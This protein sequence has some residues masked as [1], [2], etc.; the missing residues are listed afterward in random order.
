MLRTR[1]LT[2]LTI[3]AVVA[4]VALAGTA[5]AVSPAVGTASTTPARQ[6][7]T[8]ALTPLDVARIRTAGEIAI[9]PDGSQIAFTL[10][11]PREPGSE[12]NGPA[13]SELHL[14]SFDGSDHRPFV[15]GEVNVTHV[16]WSPDG[17]YVTYAARREGDDATAIYVIPA[18]GGESRRLVHYP[19]SVSNF[20]WRP[21]G[22]AVGFIAREPVDKE[23]Q[24]LRAQG[25]NQ[26]VYE[27][28]N[29]A[30]RIV[31]VELPDGPS[32]E[33]EEPRVI[34]GIA[35]HP[36]GIAWSPE[37]DR[38]VVDPAPTPLVDD[39]YMFRRLHII[40]AA[41]GSTQGKIDNPGKLGQFGWSPDGTSV[42]VISGVDINDPMQGRLMV[43]STEGEQ[44]RDILPGLAGHIAHF[45][46]T[47][48]GNI[49]YLANIGVGAQLGRVAP[50][51]SHAEVLFRSSELVIDAFSLDASGRQIA[52]VAESPT[53]PREVFALS[54]DAPNEPQR[55]TD[56]NPWLAEIGFA[57]QEILRWNAQD[58]REIEGLLIHPIE[59]AEGERVPTIVVAHGGPESH[60]KNG[61]LTGY[62][63]PGQMAA[64]RGYAVFYPNYRGSTGRG[65]E[66]TKAH[67]GD[68]GGAE[69][70]DV[71]AGVDYLIERGIADPDRVGITGASYGGYFTAWGSTRHSERFAAGVMFVGISD[72]LSKT[73]TS[74][75]PN[76]LELV[77]WLTTPYENLD[78][79]LERSPVLYI[80][81][82]QTPLLI[83]HG[84]DDP[85]V[86]PGQSRELH[87][88]LKLKGDVP[89]RL[90][91]YPGEG[92]G[93]A[94]AAARYDYSLRMLR[95]FD[96]FLKEGGTEP[97]PWRLDYGLE[98]K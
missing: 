68:G 5:P 58:G 63:S 92:H 1:H 28:D 78:L 94:R 2:L 52:L 59:R 29:T 76:E 69:F 49:V 60:Y 34:D 8:R 85:R 73:G 25:F 27:E 36:Y 21:D 88:A 51:G 15:T 30:R 44:L 95:W 54:L 74:D 56:S 40:G 82:A 87:R 10:S 17:E 48:D 3:A 9:S 47:P 80:D 37:G 23:L 79:F 39:Q 91:L 67:Q 77:H 89:V 6:A 42:V 14:V 97:P 72:Q 35:G 84:K 46:F 65:V 75:I 86:N 19:T 18:T 70:D 96:H 64:A 66:F 53:M 81:R 62:S 43:V 31:V 24:A 41:S 57:E 83:L 50:D 71:L 93:N 4:V 26:E 12:N 90:I 33:A 13:W 20:E 38:F 11:V 61:W 55:L 32:G 7:G 16:R 98:K 45:E 22:K